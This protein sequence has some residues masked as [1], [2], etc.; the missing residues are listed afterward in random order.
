MATSQTLQSKKAAG[1]DAPGFDA[2]VLEA[3]LDL[4]SRERQ[5][6]APNGERRE[7]GAG[8]HLANDK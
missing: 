6:E 2:S 8:A 5:L 3:L 1:P 7:E 4:G